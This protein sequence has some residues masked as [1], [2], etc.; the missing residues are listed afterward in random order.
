MSHS[1]LRSDCSCLL[2][3]QRY[4]VN[5]ISIAP[6]TMELQRSICYHN[7]SPMDGLPLTFPD[8]VDAFLDVDITRGMQAS[9]VVNTKS[10]LT[11]LGVTA[12]SCVVLVPVFEKVGNGVAIV[13]LNMA[14]KGQTPTIS[15]VDLYHLKGIQQL[16]FADAPPV[17]KT[18]D[19]NHNFKGMVT[20]VTRTG[21]KTLK[22]CIKS[23]VKEDDDEEEDEQNCAAS[24]Y[25]LNDLTNGNH[26][27]DEEDYYIP[28]R[29]RR[30]S[31]PN[32]GLRSST[33]RGYMLD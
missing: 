10:K 23:K 15:R 5:F 9:M 25:G 11:G 21:K 24:S 31:E 4:P 6:D 28:E 1:F 16:I 13:H 3:I 20:M 7:Y 12:D 19:H 33:C 18:T 14:D 17:T 26:G 30:R 22:S 27:N 8:T 2:G 32:P 29:F